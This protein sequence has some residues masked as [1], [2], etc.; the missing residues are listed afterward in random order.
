[1]ISRPVLEEDPPV[2][3][4]DRAED[5]GLTPISEHTEPNSA[6]ESNNGMDILLLPDVEV[7]RENSADESTI[8]GGPRDSILSIAEASSIV[9]G[10]L[11]LY[12]SYICHLHTLFVLHDWHSP[13]VIF[14]SCIF[15]EC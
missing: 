6:R 14:T 8:A 2:D 10:K 9:S 3:K 7:V 12:S 5:A 11:N 13:S 4:D 1:M 15:V